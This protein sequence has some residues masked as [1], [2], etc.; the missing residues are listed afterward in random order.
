MKSISIYSLDYFTMLSILVHDDSARTLPQNMLDPALSE[1]IVC[2]G[3]KT[4][5]FC[6][7]LGIQIPVLPKNLS[8]GFGR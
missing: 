6:K 4:V 1:M 8:W 3:Y 5:N 2:Q 7:I